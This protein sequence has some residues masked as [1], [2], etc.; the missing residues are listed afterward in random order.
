MHSIDHFHR[1]ETQWKTAVNLYRHRIVD[2]N[3][4]KQCDSV[5]NV[6][7]FILFS[8]YIVI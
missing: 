4:R 8:E 3:I 6:A 2:V 7:D 1:S 5:I